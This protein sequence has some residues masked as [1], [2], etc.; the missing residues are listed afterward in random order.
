VILKFILRLRVSIITVDPH[1][2]NVFS[3]FYVVTT[4]LN[5]GE[6]RQDR[7]LGLYVLNATFNNFSYSMVV[8][9]IGGGKRVPGE[10]HRTVASLTNFIT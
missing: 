5:G 1:F 2:Q 9:F 3:L 6:H 4:R 8:S 10:N 7:G